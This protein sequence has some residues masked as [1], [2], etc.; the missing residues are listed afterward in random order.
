[1]IK[2]QSLKFNGKRN[3]FILNQI[4]QFNEFVLWEFKIL[5][6]ILESINYFL[7]SFFLTQ[8][9]SPYAVG[10]KEWISA[11][12]WRFFSCQKNRKIFRINWKNFLVG[13]QFHLEHIE[14]YAKVRILNYKRSDH[15]LEFEFSLSQFNLI[16]N[17][18]REKVDLIYFAQKSLNSFFIANSV[19]SPW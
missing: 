4:K 10:N 12:F 3:F 13:Q 18:G 2:V 19:P 16:K 1:M 17:F 8:L 15:I 9:D 7:R 6:L 5:N 14:F 11:L